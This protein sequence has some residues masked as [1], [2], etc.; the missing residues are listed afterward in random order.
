M[1]RDVL[2]TGGPAQQAVRCLAQT[3][4]LVNTAQLLEGLR[5]PQAYPHPVEAGI[6]VHET[7]IS[8]VFL[9]GDF[10]YKI[11][12]PIKTDFL[13]YGTL[14]RRRHYCN[15]EVRL[16]GR[17]ASDLYVGVVPIGWQRG[18]LRIECESE[19]IEYAVKMRRFPKGA[20]L[21]E[22]VASGKLTTTEVHQLAQTVAAF[23]E[24]A[25][26]CSPEFAAGWPNY[27]V[28]NLGQIIVKLQA[29]AD[30]EGT[31]TLNVLKDWAAKCFEEQMDTMIRRV[32]GGFVRECHGDLHLQNVV[33]WGDRLIPFDGIEFNERLRWI[34]VLCDA[35]FLE[36]DLAYR[37][38]LDLSR[39]FMNAYL[40]CSGDYRLLK[41]LR[42]FLVYRALVRALVAS[43]R[44]AQGHL[45]M[46]EREAIARDVR[47]HIRL[48]YRFTLTE[49]PSVWIT[50][51]V[52]GS[53]KTTLSEIIVQRH[54]A[55]RLRSDVERKRLFGLSPTQRPAAELQAK[56]YG[57]EANLQT[58]LRLE[59]LA[60]DILRA[61]YSTIIDATFLKRS[62]RDRC[63]DFAAR[64]GAQFAILDC[65]SDEQT[66][67][68][69][70]ADR[71]TT[72]LD[73]SDADLNVLEHQLAS[74]EPLTASELGCAVHI[75]D[76]AEI[77]GKL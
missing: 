71:R 29:T 66:L 9:A 26:C 63:R 52:S 67:L 43:F 62:D 33:H 54:D 12:K 14:E 42:P 49:A 16:D 74:R 35:A 23:H 24:R 64:E 40:E 27:F 30:P 7:H 70:V 36:M 32:K 46:C 13:D 3:D 50:H 31:M 61:G 25:A 47:E 34:D 68:Q 44:S 38:H 77:V 41:I 53:G 56:M 2:T 73:A 58:Y 37:G 1:R 10:A 28:Q 15:E 55:F 17:Y 21:S 76:L 4:P 69:R 39:S 59:S 20:L 45:T 75:P 60:R 8:I 51:G 72:N 22:R 6:E 5:Q 19:P 11:K 48:A 18:Q 57:V 65:H